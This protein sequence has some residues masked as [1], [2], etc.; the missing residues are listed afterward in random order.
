MPTSFYVQENKFLTIVSG[1]HNPI[2]DYVAA[3]LQVLALQ[4]F[5]GCPK[6]TLA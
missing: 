2:R 5:Q 4:L 6:S 1:G 3:I